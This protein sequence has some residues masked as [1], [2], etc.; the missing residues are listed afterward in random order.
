MRGDDVHSV[1][2]AAALVG[3]FLGR[4]LIM[5][6]S[7]LANTGGEEDEQVSLPK[8]AKMLGVAESTLRAAIR[9]GE[10]DAVRCG[11]KLLFFKL[12]DIHEYKNR[13]VL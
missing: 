5:L 13:K 12:S 10:L 11:P 2:E 8:A 1:A 7:R 4:S 9:R 3:S 6:V